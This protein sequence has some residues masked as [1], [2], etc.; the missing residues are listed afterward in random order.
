MVRIADKAV[1][2]N[3]RK[4]EALVGQTVAV[5]VLDGFTGA[6]QRL[7][8]TVRCSGRSIGEHKGLRVLVSVSHCHTR[9][10]VDP[11]TKVAHPPLTVHS[12]PMRAEIQLVR[13]VRRRLMLES[14]HGPCRELVRDCSSSGR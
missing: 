3:G 10:G 13:L 12:H 2:K 9:L 1:R 5:T 14:R 6:K 11:I 7:V 4:P 8:D